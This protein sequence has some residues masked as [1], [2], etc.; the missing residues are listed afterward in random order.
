MLHHIRKSDSPL[1]IYFV[2]MPYVGADQ[3]DIVRSGNSSPQVFSQLQDF[4][5]PH[6]RPS[7]DTDTVTNL[8]DSHES[9][10][11]G[12]SD[13]RADTPVTAEFPGEQQELQH[14]PPVLPTSDADNKVQEDMPITCSNNDL[15]S[16]AQ[17]D[18]QSLGLIDSEIVEGLFSGFSSGLAVFVRNVLQNRLLS[19]VSLL[20]V[21]HRRC[22]ELMITS[23][24]DMQWDTICTPTRIKFAREKEVSTTMHFSLYI[25]TV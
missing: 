23:A 25:H 12:I 8:T 2:K 1:P 17:I 11:G 13:S 24:Y 7:S 3:T 6:S 10:N 19:T 5:C 4:I 21:I 16:L 20:H 22:L 18:C 14:F 9:D 15:S